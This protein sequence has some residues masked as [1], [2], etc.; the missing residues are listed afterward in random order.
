MSDDRFLPAVEIDAEYAVGVIA[1]MFDVAP[2][3]G[4]G[5]KSFPCPICA[6][7][8]QMVE[9]AVKGEGSMLAILQRLRP[10]IPEGHPTEDCIPCQ[11][12]RFEQQYAIDLIKEVLP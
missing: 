1:A 8:R 12:C 5:P 4:H 7:W 2:D 10:T 3:S 11:G 9:E 6:G